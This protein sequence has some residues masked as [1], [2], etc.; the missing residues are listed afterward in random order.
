MDNWTGRLLF[1]K[2]AMHLN[3]YDMNFLKTCFRWF[4][5][6]T[7]LDMKHHINKE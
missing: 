4:N 7:S 2:R 6:F 3:Y 5:I 1:F